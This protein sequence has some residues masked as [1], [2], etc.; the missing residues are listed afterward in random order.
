[1]ETS[2]KTLLIIV[3]IIIISASGLGAFYLFRKYSNVSSEEAVVDNNVPSK[4]FLV[5]EYPSGI[6]EEW[7][8]ESNPQIISRLTYTNA[9]KTQGTLMYESKLDQKTV[10]TNYENFL[11]G[12]GW[13]T[14]TTEDKKAGIF[15]VNA[16]SAEHRAY[17]VID[18]NDISKVVTVDITVVKN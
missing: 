7:I 18:Q 8:L 5:N 12:K 9:G 17:I 11:K 13:V 4:Q 15:T 14:T 3:V 1:M 6:T 16:V 2:K 10:A